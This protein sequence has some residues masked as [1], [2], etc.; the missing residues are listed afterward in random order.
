M[1]FDNNFKFNKKD[2]EKGLKLPDEMSCELA[3]IV[4]IHFGDGCMHIKENRSYRLSY[5]CNIA[6]ERY[7]AYIANQFKKLFNIS[8]TIDKRMNKSSIELSRAPWGHSGIT[9]SKSAESGIG[10]WWPKRTTRS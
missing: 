2:I 8:C 10:V 7:S 1:K 3:E 4:G 9:V 6:E 5:A